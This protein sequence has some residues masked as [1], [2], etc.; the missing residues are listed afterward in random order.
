[1]AKH[2]ARTVRE[3]RSQV[4]K[5]ENFPTSKDIGKAQKLAA[6]VGAECLAMFE[7]IDEKTKVD[8]S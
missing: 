1:M 4:R 2:R 3:R 8:N 5:S 7:A 6:K